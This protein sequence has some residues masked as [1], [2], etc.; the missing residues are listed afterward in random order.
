MLGCLPVLVERVEVE[1]R[2]V[3]LRGPGHGWEL[4]ENSIEEVSPRGGPVA[5]RAEDCHLSESGPGAALNSTRPRQR[6]KDRRRSRTRT[7]RSEGPAA[8]CRS[9]C[10]NPAR[11]DNHPAAPYRPARA[12]AVL[13][14]IPHTRDPGGTSLH[15]PPGKPHSCRV[16]AL[17]SLIIAKRPK[18]GFEPPL[19]RSN[20]TNLGHLTA[21]RS[22]PPLRMAT[23]IPRTFRTMK[24]WPPTFGYHP[25]V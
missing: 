11:T 22:L 17:F 3:V 9:H 7:R 2:D 19:C 20:L 10:P 14:A 15:M 4:P 13:S 23:I 18:I 25:A 8:P 5:L 1:V 16:R 21:R 24:I 12:R 6:A